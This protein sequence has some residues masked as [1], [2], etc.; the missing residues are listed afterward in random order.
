MKSTAVDESL[1]SMNQQFCSRENQLLQKISEHCQSSFIKHVNDM[2][3]APMEEEYMHIL[4]A[5]CFI[6]EECNTLQWLYWW[7]ARRIHLI[8][9]Y[10]GF[11]IPGLNLAEAGQSILIEDKPN[12]L[13][14]AVY[15]DSSSMFIQNI[16]F[17]A[18][19]QNR[20][21][22]MGREPM[23]RE[24]AGK[25]CT[26]QEAWGDIYLDDMLGQMNAEDLKAL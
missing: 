17:H 13:I 8:P 19:Q 12:M 26:R 1:S 22:E 4:T 24:V 7:D 6:C 10:R 3:E 21:D 15:M 2:C 9:A 14:D 5:L 16:R 20:L 23:Q 25:E 11:S 18:L